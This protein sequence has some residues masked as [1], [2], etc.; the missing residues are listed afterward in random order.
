[1][2]V[3]WLLLAAAPENAPVEGVTFRDT[4]GLIVVGVLITVLWLAFRRLKQLADQP[5]EP[6]KPSEPKPPR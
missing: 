6:K 3:T 2:H 1:M 5:E 4:L